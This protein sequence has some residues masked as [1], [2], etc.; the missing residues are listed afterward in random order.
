VTYS[1]IA[2]WLDDREY[3][4]LHAQIN[5]M[6]E[7]LRANRPAPGRRRRIIGSVFLPAEESPA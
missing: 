2:L 4:D 1:L 5:A 6:L 3:A 7:P